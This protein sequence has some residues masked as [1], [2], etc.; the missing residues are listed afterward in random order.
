MDEI[1]VRAGHTIVLAAG[2]KLNSSRTVAAH[3]GRDAIKIA[4]CTI[5]V[6]PR[7]SNATR[8]KLLLRTH[9]PVHSTQRD[10]DRNRSCDE[11]VGAKRSADR[12]SEERG[13]RCACEEAFTDRRS[14]ER[15]GVS[16]IFTWQSC[17]VFQRTSGG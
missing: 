17:V 13:Q 8:K 5:A 3:Q 14:R 16:S 11:I 6:I 2:A 10:T 4:S 12:G 1:C 15:D 9:S 7:R